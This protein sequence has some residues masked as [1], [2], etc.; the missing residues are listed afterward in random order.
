MTRNQMTEYTTAELVAY[1]ERKDEQ[2]KKAPAFIRRTSFSN[3]NNTSAAIC[4]EI[5]SRMLNK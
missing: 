2:Y 3:W 5:Q 1:V 4:A